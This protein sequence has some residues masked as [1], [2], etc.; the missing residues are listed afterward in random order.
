MAVPSGTAQPPQLLTPAFRSQ[1]CTPACLETVPKPQP[2]PVT[3]RTCC[4]WM[5]AVFSSQTHLTLQRWRSLQV[6]RSSSCLSISL[7]PWAHLC[8][9]ITNELQREKQVCLPSNEVTVPALRSILIL[10]KLV[11]L[12]PNELQVYGSWVL[13]VKWEKCTGGE[14]WGIQR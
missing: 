13:R 4:L 8:D 9:Q 5:S 2:A 11:S 3:T 7:V 6:G 12:P 14:N 10:N 1:S